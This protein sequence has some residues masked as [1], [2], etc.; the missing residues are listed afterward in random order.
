M[1]FTFSHIALRWQVLIKNDTLFAN[2]LIVLFSL[3]SV[4]KAQRIC[5]ESFG[6]ILMKLRIVIYPLSLVY[7]KDRQK[8]QT[9]NLLV[10]VGHRASF[11]TIH[12]CHCATKVARDNT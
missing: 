12:L 6:I 3:G 10:L 11:E 1:A 4:F 7:T 9:V 5:V 8:G 2:L